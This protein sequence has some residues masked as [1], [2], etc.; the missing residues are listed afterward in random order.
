M[1][2][3]YIVLKLTRRQQRAIQEAGFL[4]R[5]DRINARGEKT[6]VVAQ[7][8]GDRI[9]VGM[10]PTERAAEVFKGVKN[11]PLWTEEEDLLS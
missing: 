1:A 5:V 7:V 8:F 9:H 4:R 2:Y 3:P 10:L 6:C 11:M